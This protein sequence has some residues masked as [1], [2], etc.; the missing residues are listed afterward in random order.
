MQSRRRAV[1]SNGRCPLVQPVQEPGASQPD[2]LG[3]EGPRVACHAKARVCLAGSMP[4]ERPQGCFPI[5]HMRAASWPLL[6]AQKASGALLVLCS[7]AAAVAEFTPSHAKQT[8]TVLATR[9]SPGS[10]TAVLP[11][12][13]WAGRGQQEGA[14]A[15]L[16]CL[17]RGPEQGTPQLGSR[18][19]WAP[20]QHRQ[21]TLGP[22]VGASLLHPR[23]RVPVLC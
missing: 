14:A 18:R 1:D 13:L 4:Q 5:D 11:V 10:Q 12:T 9:Q 17:H 16:L 3:W 19:P 21:W 15:H 6:W 8:G 22:P 20:W 7:A 23:G 2:A